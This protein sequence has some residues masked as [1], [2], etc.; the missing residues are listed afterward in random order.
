MGF[1]GAR[2]QRARH[3]ANCAAAARALER[4]P[5]QLR[6]RLRLR[7][8]VLT[9]RREESLD[10]TLAVCRVGYLVCRVG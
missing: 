8:R 9:V 4:K 10:I 1:E 7:V 3:R 5:A 2:E 6:G